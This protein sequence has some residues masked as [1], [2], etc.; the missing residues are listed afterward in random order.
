VATKALAHTASLIPVTTAKQTSD[1]IRSI[2]SAIQS[3]RGAVA[4]THVLG[5]Q[6]GSGESKMTWIPRFG[7]WAC[8]EPYDGKLRTRHWLAYGLVDPRATSSNLNI[9]VETAV[10]HRGINRRIAGLIAEDGSGNAYLLHSGKIGGGKKGF[11]KS[12]FWKHYNGDSV[13]VS[14][15][16]GEREYAL[17]GLIDSQHFVE[18]LADFIHGVDALRSGKLKYQWRFP[19]GSENL[20]FTKKQ[21]GTT[22]VEP[23]KTIIVRSRTHD[24]VVNALKKQLDSYSFVASIG[25]DIRDLHVVLTNGE[26]IDVEVKTA[27]DRYDIY[28][29]VG[30]LLLN[31]DRT[32]LVLV[33]P[34]DVGEAVDL[35][36][37]L[38]ELSISHV[39]Y[40]RSADRFT[41][42]GLDA[43]FR[44][45]KAPQPRKRQAYQRRR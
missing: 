1:A 30:Q 17:I 42:T 28:T 29:A 43:A 2:R 24:E 23:S 13:S 6:G 3:A 44:A 33:T 9:R 39:G 4:C 37:R 38:G 40:K 12:F 11:G 45:T 5:A 34:S 21:G 15:D 26:R 31:Q 14:F 7:F 20:S 18:R 8:I 32:R 35:I 19:K 25:D 27:T 22:E 10:P 41:F 36:T 16:D